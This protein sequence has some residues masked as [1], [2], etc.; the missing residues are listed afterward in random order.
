MSSSTNGSPESPL[1]RK[2]L[3][4]EPTLL[5]AVRILLV[6]WRI[7]ITLPV[8]V[9]LLIVLYTF[10]FQGR[11]FLARASFYAEETAPNIGGLAGVAAE[12]GVTL[13]EGQAAASPEFYAEL[14]QSNA[15]L[16]EAVNSQYLV[17]EPPVRSSRTTGNRVAPPTLSLVQI[18][19]VRGSTPHKRT[20]RAIDRLKGAMTVRVEAGS[21]LV[22]FSTRAQSATLA[23]QIADRLIALLNQFDQS[24]RHS[25]YSAERTFVGQQLRR[26]RG[27]L[28]LAEDS[29]ERFLIENRQF[30]N[31]PGLVLEHDRLQRNV[32]FHQ[33][34]YTSLAQSYEQARIEE[35]RDVPVITMVETPRATVQS[36]PRGRLAKILLGL[37][38][39][40]LAAVGWALFV[41]WKRNLS[42]RHPES[43]EDISGRLN[44]ALTELRNAGRSLRRRR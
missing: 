11:R 15:L 6:H 16:A 12:F 35:V 36:A 39:A 13:P 25:R 7:V 28:R 8:A 29:L 41:E 43:Y 17:Q 21:G 22:V 10:A 9:G 26:E 38:V 27:D 24:Q 4:D 19:G 42:L 1:K 20:L 2:L 40:F 37:L 34:V 3:E 18:Y 32:D 30:D 33:Q 5:S 23:V 14:L 31:S 44:Q